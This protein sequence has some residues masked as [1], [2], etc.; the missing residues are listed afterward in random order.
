MRAAGPRAAA[1]AT[2]ATGTA[3]GVGTAD[4]AAATTAALRGATNG[5]LCPITLLEQA[6]EVSGAARTDEPSG[7][8]D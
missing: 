5:A 2:A 1:A 8:K 7:E 4:R 3:T 6:T